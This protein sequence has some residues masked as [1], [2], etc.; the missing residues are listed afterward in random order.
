MTSK[1]TLTIVGT[2]DEINLLIDVYAA[3]LGLTNATQKDKETAALDQ[4][5]VVFREKLVLA[6]VIQ[7][8]AEDRAALET[9]QQTLEANLKAKKDSFELT[10]SVAVDA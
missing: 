8:R 9:F 5:L 6:A 3:E 1:R 4:L 7:K 10:L 2:E